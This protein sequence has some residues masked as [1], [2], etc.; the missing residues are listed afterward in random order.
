MGAD[1]LATMTA[2]THMG[3]EIECNETENKVIVNGVG[4][5]GLQAPID[6]LDLGNSGTAIRLLTGLLAGQLFDITLTGDESLC[7]RPM[8]RVVEPLRRMGAK[9]EMSVTG[10]PP[11]KI[12]GRNALSGIDYQLPMA[13]AQVKSCL[14]LAG[15]YA[16]GKT[17]ITEPAPTRDHTERLLKLFGYAIEQQKNRVCLM[18]GGRLTA[19]NISVPGDISSAAFFMVAATITPGAKITLRQIGLN[20]TRMGILNLLTMMGADIKIK[21]QCEKSG[22]PVGDITVCYAK[23]HGIEIPVDQVP[24]AID[25]FPVLF[26]AAATATGKTVLRGATELRVKESDRIAAMAS[27][28]TTL[29]IETQVL[30]DGIIIHGGVFQGGE[31]D[32]VGDHRIAM[33]FA[34]AGGI[35]QAPVFVR[36]CA[37]VQTSFPNFT[38]L[39]NEIGMKIEIE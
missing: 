13:S 14:L 26:I 31:I 28:L 22:E 36:N 32:S 9:I 20:P 30:P 18:G 34:I 6:V 25:E 2:F 4:L 1:N 23:L 29:G 12:S 39:A 27:G 5:N 24:L 38:E 11:L 3:V 21:N 16:N 35:A 7:R 33:A 19:T 37:N 15:L 10:T 17:C 8:A